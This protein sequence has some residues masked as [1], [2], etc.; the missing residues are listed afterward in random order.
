MGVRFRAVRAIS[1]GRRHTRA[2]RALGA[3]RRDE[4]A[5]N[6]ALEAVRTGLEGGTPENAR[7]V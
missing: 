2:V 4:I 5:P 6:E 7:I 3:A 1:R